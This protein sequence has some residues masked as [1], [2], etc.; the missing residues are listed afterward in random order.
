MSLHIYVLPL[1]AYFSGDFETIFE[2]LSDIAGK[3]GK[4]L[5]PEGLVE[6][7][8]P[9]PDELEVRKR[10]SEIG[11]WVTK[12]REQIR[13]RFAVE[14]DW[15]ESGGLRFSTNMSYTTYSGMFEWAERGG[16]HQSEAL[17]DLTTAQVYLPLPFEGT[18]E[19]DCPFGD[20]PLRIGSSITLRRMIEPFADAI[21]SNAEWRELLANAERVIHGALAEISS[22]RDTVDRWLHICDMSIGQRAPIVTE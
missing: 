9:C 13:Q 2:K 5:T 6:P 21:Q 17:N 20:A 19:F 12:L 3:P 4:L 10:R 11:P 8:P 18:A 14:A 22:A 7:A 15:D 1:T 16:A